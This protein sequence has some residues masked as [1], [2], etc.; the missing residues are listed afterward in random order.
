VSGA[1]ARGEL[2]LDALSRRIEEW[3]FGD[4]A[5]D[6]FTKDFDFHFCAWF[7]VCDWQVGVGDG[8]ADRVALAARFNSSDHLA[9]VADWFVAKSHASDVVDQDRSESSRDAIF[10]DGL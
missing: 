6:P 10:L 5:V 4:C 3:V 1:T 8:L 7:A 2:G 9:F